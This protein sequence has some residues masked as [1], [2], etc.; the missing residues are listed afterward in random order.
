MNLQQD[1]RI[2]LEE[3]DKD[4]R[5]LGQIEAIIDVYKAAG[6]TRVAFDLEGV[7][8]SDGPLDMQIGT[9]TRKHAQPV[10]KLFHDRL[11]KEPFI[12]TAATREAAS[13]ILYRSQLVV[14][15]QMNLIAREDYAAALPYE[16]F[17]DADM[18]GFYCDAREK[19]PALEATTERFREFVM[20]VAFAR[21][22][23]RLRAFCN[24]SLPVDLCSDDSRKTIAEFGLG[25]GENRDLL[26][27]W[28][29]EVAWRLQ[30]GHIKIPQR[31]GVDILLDDNGK[32]HRDA[33]V[34]INAIES[35]QKVRDVA[36]FA[37][38]ALYHFEFDELSDDEPGLE[39]SGKFAGIAFTSGTTEIF[40][41]QEYFDRD[42]SLLD[43]L[44]AAVMPPCAASMQPAPES[45]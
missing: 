22:G 12:W 5:L 39:I 4:P 13:K 37:A 2:Q 8:V 24:N 3:S 40:N 19:Y 38:T 15:P 43:S 21:G 32:R 1:Y 41:A 10:L 29:F 27:Q 36:R 28:A 16:Y 26:F 18:L 31:L 14:P 23:S 6:I 25:A 7:L 20:K 9:L 33:C 34:L 45:T 42:S 44:R 11:G 17:S 30:S 35:A